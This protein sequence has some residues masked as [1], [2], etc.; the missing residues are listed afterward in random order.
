[1]SHQG[2]SRQSTELEAFWQ[3]P[4]PQIRHVV[5]PLVF[6]KVP[7]GHD[8]HDCKADFSLRKVPGGQEA[9][10]FVDACIS[11]TQPAPTLRKCD[12]EPECFAALADN[13]KCRSSNALSTRVGE[14]DEFITLNPLDLRPGWA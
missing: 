11:M 3:Y 13:R 5:E 6:E 10:A 2:Q 4:G 7:A 14:G 8:S 9:H 1:M 12:A